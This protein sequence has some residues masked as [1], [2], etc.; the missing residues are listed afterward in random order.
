MDPDDQNQNDTTY[1]PADDDAKHQ[2][3]KPPSVSGEEDAFSGDMP[4]EPPDIDE[5]LE[6]VGLKGDSEEGI[7][8]LGVSDELHEEEE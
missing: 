7:K 4:A 3:A 2:E 8:P 1:T 6:K 5:E